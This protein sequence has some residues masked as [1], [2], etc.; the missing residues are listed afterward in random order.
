LQNGYKTG[1]PP[2]IKAADMIIGSAVSLVYQTHL[3]KQWQHLSFWSQWLSHLSHRFLSWLTWVP[4]PHME[5]IEMWL[6]GWLVGWLV[7][8]Q[9]NCTS[10]ASQRFWQAVFSFSLDS[11]NF[12]SSFIYSM[13]HRYFNLIL[14]FQRTNIFCSIL[15]LFCTFKNAKLFI[16]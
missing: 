7:A 12:S 6:V 15:F 3:M 9:Y 10:V 5:P 8:Q 13:I 14:S 11:K 4:S 16:I 2:S 1:L